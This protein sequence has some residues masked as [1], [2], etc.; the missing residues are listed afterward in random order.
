M[1]RMIPRRT[2]LEERRICWRCWMCSLDMEFRGNFLVRKINL[3]THW[4]RQCLWLWEFGNRSR[5]KKVWAPRCRHLKIYFR[6][7]KMRENQLESGDK[8]TKASEAWR[9]RFLG[10]REVSNCA[11][12]CWWT[13]E[14]GSREWCHNGV[15]QEGFL[16]TLRRA[17]INQDRVLSDSAELIA[18]TEG[19]LS[20]ESLGEILIKE[21]RN[22]NSV[23]VLTTV[24]SMERKSWWC[25]REKGRGAG[26]G[27]CWLSVLDKASVYGTHSGI[28]VA[29]DGVLNRSQQWS[30]G[31]WR[32][33][34]LTFVVGKQELVTG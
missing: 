34:D 21:K 5:K 25:Q 29:G 22:S 27:R 2:S 16:K 23:S 4:H 10:G 19:I 26:V 9:R 14:V 8:G 7:P 18:G 33:T 11:R 12:R 24:I 6:D 3:G 20:H 17:T 31:K 30:W 13:R 28:A 1:K 15:H 32:G